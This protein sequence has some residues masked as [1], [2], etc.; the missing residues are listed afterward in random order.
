MTDV[1]MITWASLHREVLLLT[2]FEK[3]TLSKANEQR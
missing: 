1:D 3:V 2:R